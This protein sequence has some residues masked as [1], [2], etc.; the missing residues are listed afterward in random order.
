MLTTPIPLGQPTFIDAPRCTD[1][2]TLVAD[3]AIIGVPYGY[4]YTMDAVSSPSGPAP[5]AIR[6][7]SGSRTQCDITLEHYD[8]DF[9]GP[10]FAGHRVRIVDCGDVTMTPGAFFFNDTATT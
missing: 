5:A 3:F 6:E 9:G 8:F 2:S 7:Q 1:L 4:S 10:L